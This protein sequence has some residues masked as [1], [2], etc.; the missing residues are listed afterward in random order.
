MADRNRALLTA[1]GKDPRLLVH[2]HAPINL[3]TPLAALEG[4]LTPTPLFFVRNN[5]SFPQIAPEDWRLRIDGLVRRP[6]TIDYAT[7]RRLPAMSYVAVLQCSGLRRLDFAMQGPLPEGI[8][9]HS[10]A[11]GNA[12]WVGVPVRHLL[13]LADVDAAALQAECIGGDA[14]HT[15]RGVEVAKLMEDAIL[16]YAMN[17]E[18]LPAIH[19]GPVRLLVPGWGGINSIK[20]IVGLRLIAHESDSVYNQQKYVIEDA[21]GKRRGKV[22]AVPSRTSA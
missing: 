10:G 14:G 16:A 17:G 9:W 19:G 3:E 20:W 15:T 13:E 21:A 2:S 7:L 5:D 12:E 22:R 8:A 4:T 11:V 1:L 6:L 18:L